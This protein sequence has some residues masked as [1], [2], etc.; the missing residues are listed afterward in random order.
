MAKVITQPFEVGHAATINLTIDGQVSSHLGWGED[1]ESKSGLSSFLQNYLHGIDNPITITGLSKLPSFAPTDPPHAPQWLLS[2]LP[3]LS[4]PLSF[5][6]PKPPPKII[7]EVTIE[8]M[9]LT[10]SR[11]K[12]RASG[13]V[14]VIISLPPGLEGMN[15]NVQEI[16]PDILVYDGPAS[17]DPA[18]PADPPQKAFGHIK[19][20]EYINSTTIPS[21]L[22]GDPSRMIVKAPLKDVEVVILKGRDSVLSD[23]VGKVVFKGGALAGIKGSAS[24]R[25]R[26]GGTE[27]LVALNELP[28]EGEVWVGKQRLS[29]E[30]IS[31]RVSGL[32][33]E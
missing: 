11:G 2:T 13:E 30:L 32:A 9:R 14:V 7:Q 6:A 22:P 18:D 28:V 29:A 8:R 15:I 10:E 24:V 17:S 25:V 26:I 21:P 19:P 33:E 23:F 12:M 16:Q 4:L 3:S 1:G 27:G 31:L 5:P 20:E